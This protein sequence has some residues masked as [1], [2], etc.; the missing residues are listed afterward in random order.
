[1]SGSLQL[2][3]LCEIPIGESR[4]GTLWDSRHFFL[5]VLWYFF[6]LLSVEYKSLPCFLPSKKSAFVLFYCV[7][8]RAIL[9][10]LFPFVLFCIS[11]LFFVLKTNLFHAYLPSKKID[12]KKLIFKK[13]VNIIRNFEF[14]VGENRIFIYRYSFDNV[15]GFLHFQHRITKE[16]IL[17]C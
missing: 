3:V 9:P 11:S 15:S 14:V 2:N 12:D 13:P 17:R 7:R 8:P 10:F 6:A 1:V 5:R 16:K 4:I